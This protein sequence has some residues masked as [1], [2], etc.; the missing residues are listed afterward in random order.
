MPAINAHSG[1]FQIRNH[2]QNAMCFK[3]P[4]LGHNISGSRPL[5]P[6]KCVGV[7]RLNQQLWRSILIGDNGTGK[8]QHV[9]RIIQNVFIIRISTAGPQDHTIFK[10][11]QPF[12]NNL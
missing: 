3:T 7:I 6:T 8:T 12:M 11:V 9:L 10:W 2:V 5:A 4:C 1:G